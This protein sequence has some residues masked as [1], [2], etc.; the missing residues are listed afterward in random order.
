VKAKLKS[1]CLKAEFRVSHHSSQVRQYRVEKRDEC[2]ERDEHGGNIGN[3]RDGSG[4]SLG[5]SLNNISFFSE[6]ICK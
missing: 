1:T 3:Q 2:E 5:R 4:R 6:E